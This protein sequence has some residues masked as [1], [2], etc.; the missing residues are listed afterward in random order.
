M[1]LGIKRPRKDGPCTETKIIFDMEIKFQVIVYQLTG[2]PCAN[3]V[4]RVTLL[5]WLADS[6]Y[7][8]K[9]LGG[10]AVSW[11]RISKSG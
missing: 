8:Q 3:D 5:F 9:I 11:Q 7:Y 1:I 4:Q 10:H 2:F 6:L